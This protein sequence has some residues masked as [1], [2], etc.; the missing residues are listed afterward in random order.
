VDICDTIKIILITS[1]YYVCNIG[2]SGF[3]IIAGDD[4]V[5]PILAY[6]IAG[7]FPISNIPTNIMKW[8]NQYGEQIDYP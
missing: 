7:T 3:V 2:K 4:N 6:S 5:T 8:L 1:Q